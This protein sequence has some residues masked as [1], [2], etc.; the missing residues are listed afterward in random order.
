[1]HYFRVMRNG[2]TERKN[3]REHGNSKGW[4]SSNGYIVKYNPS[5]PLARGTGDILEHREV[6]YNSVGEK[7]PDCDICG[8]PTSWEIYKYHVDH[9]DKD[10]KNNDISNLRMLCN[11]CNV[12]RTEKVHCNSVGRNPVTINGVSMTAQEW[13]REE[14]VLVSGATIR[15]RIKNGSSHYDA[16]YSKRLTHNSRD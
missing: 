2:T 7:T 3:R 13:S 9:I 6:L 10:K 11:S 5:H 8:C 15:L 1:M 14:G 16:V 4:V 12:G